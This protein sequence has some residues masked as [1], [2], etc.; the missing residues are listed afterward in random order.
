MHSSARLCKEGPRQQH[1]QPGGDSWLIAA[2]LLGMYVVARYILKVICDRCT[3]SKLVQALS[4][5]K[6]TSADQSSPLQQVEVLLVD[7]ALE[8]SSWLD[9]HTGN[10]SSTSSR[11]ITKQKAERNNSDSSS[12]AGPRIVEG[13]GALYNLLYQQHGFV[14]FYREQ[15]S[16]GVWR[17]GWVRQPYRMKAR[18]AVFSGSRDRALLQQLLS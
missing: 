3:V 14:G 13:L 8:S 11:R 1:L 15:L 17:F 4:D 16:D 9:A 6:N 12:S 7:L 2:V 10:G 18:T 5:S